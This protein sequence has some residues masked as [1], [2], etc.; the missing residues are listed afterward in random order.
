MRLRIVIIPLA[1]IL[2]IATLLNAQGG[3]TGAISG[4]VQDQS[5]AVVPRAQI[6]IAGSE[7]TVRHVE[8]DASGSFTVPLLPVGSY[9]LLIK[10][11]GF[12]ETRL[13]A[14]EVRVTETTKL[15]AVLRPRSIATQ[16][17]V[18]ARVANVETTSAVTGQSLTAATITTLP[19]ATQ[20]FQQLLSLS[21]GTTSNLN[22]SASLGRGDTRIDVNGQREDNNNYEI[23]GITAS[24]YNVAE[25][26]NTPLP[27]PDVVQEFKVQT[28]LYD[29]TQGRNGGGNI[30][31]VLKSGTNHFHGDAFEFFR[32]DDLNANEFFLNSQGNPR[33]IVKQNIFGGSLGGPILP[34]G[35]WGYFF[36]NY[37]GTRQQSGLSSG[38]IIGTSLPVVPL[39]RSA[40]SLIQTFFPNN[41][42]VSVSDID[43]VALKL[44]NLQRNQFGATPGGYL[45]PTVAG[46]PGSTGQFHVSRPG[47]YND[48][49]FTTNYD[50]EFGSKDKIS[51]RFFFSNFESLLPFGAGGLQASFGGGISPTDL[52]FPYYLPV[53][54]RFLNV[55]ETHI[56]T[57][58]WVNEFRFGFVRINNSDINVPIVTVNDLGINR[59][60]NNVDN[61][62]YKFTF[63]SSGFQ[64]GPTPGAD[65]TQLQNNFIFL[66]TTSWS[67]GRHLIRFGGEAD[68]IDL[69]K[70]FPQVF[71]GQL[72]FSPGTT[73]SGPCGSG[74]S[75][76]QEF[77]LGAPSFSYGGGGVANHQYRINDFSLFVQDDYRLNPNFTLNVGLR[78][79][80]NGAV[81]DH[82]CHIGNTIPSLANA[83]QNP[84]VYPT[85]VNSL[86]IPGLVGTRNA[87]TLNNEYASNWGPRFGFAYNLFGKSATA[88]RGGYGIYYVRE[89]VGAVDQLS[90]QAPFL[91]ITS[92]VGTPGQMAN[93]FAT[94]A[95]RLPVGGVIDP[96][97]VP[98]YSQ[99]QGFVDA[100]G[101][102]TRDTTQTPVYNGNTI[103]ILALEVPPHYV[104][105]STQQWN[106]T[107]QQSLGRNW[108]LELGYV[109][110][111]GTHLRDTRD[112]DQSYDARTNPVTL[113]ATD[114]TTYVVTQNTLANVNARGRY[115]GLAVASFQVFANDANSIYNAFVA[116]ISHRFSH[117]LQFQGAYTFS[118]AIDETSTGNTSLNS[119]VNDQ[120]TLKDS[121]GLADFDRTNR[122]IISYTY[123]LPFFANEKGLRHAVLGSWFIS[124][125]TTFQSGAPFTVLDSA[126][127]SAFGLLGTGTPTTPDLILGVNP[128]TPGSTK[129]RLNNYVNINAFSPA[130]AI[131]PDGST[132][133]G[134]LGRNTFRGP[135]E[136]NWDFSVGK[137]FMIKETQQLRITADFFNLFNHANF[138]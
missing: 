135:F 55:T 137:I 123:D 64:I 101:N 6:E 126:A 7:G 42:N 51:G 75:D 46:T 61:L 22:A 103:N 104:N 95:G 66:N 98:V 37:Q 30:D 52:N 39:D 133:F 47:T 17:D 11:P 48:D 58:A 94:G 85:C 14:V 31:A 124:G 18:Q 16:V 73:P 72:F 33:P 40:Q 87:T 89:D 23:E 116:T 60:N 125:I 65:Q 62:I 15:T 81:Q 25:L 26:T 10:A 79:E 59:P 119:A 91:P 20:N 3:A 86:N 110:T 106:L 41:P 54:D 134:N 77:L 138:A 129:S 93:I 99:L 21:A 74:C 68:R 27:S 131:G 29:A 120:V 35:K 43:P 105:P 111:K 36:V 19:L 107:L 83:G 63:N 113:T 49:Q 96:A 109:G 97:Y 117:G 88:I 4:T 127:A 13:S 50:K 44:L 136:Q 53:N 9:T 92:S 45:F 132:G 114:G 82:L 130:P 84:Y 100:N 102:P 76:F 118:R 69:D 122:L 8:S 5:S 24:D 38:T 112:A 121:R 57:P 115:P 12:A 70:L 34:Q 2:F 56:F 1:V 90:F 108:V 32:N 128:V 71:N 28:S 80:L 67:R 78:W